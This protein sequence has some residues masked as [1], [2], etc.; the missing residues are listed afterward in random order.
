MTGSSRN[1][2]FIKAPPDKAYAAFMDPAALLAWLPVGHGGT[3]FT[4]PNGGAYADVATAWL[5]WQLKGDRRAGRMF[6]GK[7]CGLC[8]DARWTVQRKK[9]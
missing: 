2:Q 5:D 9:L 6:T 7:D 1:A 4:E 3:Y 8:R